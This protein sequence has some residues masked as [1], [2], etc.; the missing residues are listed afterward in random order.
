MPDGPQASWG[1]GEDYLL[2]TSPAFSLLNVWI[3]GILLQSIILD[4]CSMGLFGKRLEVFADM[5]EWRVIAVYTTRLYQ[6]LLKPSLFRLLL[7]ALGISV[8]ALLIALAFSSS[9]LFWLL[10]NKESVYAI[11]TSPETGSAQVVLGIFAASAS[12]S[13][14]VASKLRLACASFIACISVSAFLGFVVPAVLDITHAMT[15][16]RLS[17]EHW[18]ANLRLARYQIGRRLLNFTEWAGQ[19]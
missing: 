15:R 7:V 4:C 9:L 18:G 3:C 12:S 2:Y 14:D 13:M 17:M 16:L 19:P 11:A 10:E 8:A 6:K 5:L 1:T